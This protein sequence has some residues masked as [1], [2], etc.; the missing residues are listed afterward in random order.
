MS[1]FIKTDS[2]NIMIKSNKFLNNSGD[3]G[4]ALNLEHRGASV[5][6]IDNLFQSQKNLKHIIGC[7]NCI[8]TTGYWN[9]HTL[10]ILNTYNDSF[11]IACG[12]ISIFG[13]SFTDINSTY[14]SNANV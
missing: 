1:V 9:T 4:S 11:S 12:V 13:A 2:S 3:F 6:V 5:I 14:L 8:K 10:S 7:G